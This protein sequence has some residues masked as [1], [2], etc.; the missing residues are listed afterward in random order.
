MSFNVFALLLSLC[1]FP[2]HILAI[3]QRRISPTQHTQWHQGDRAHDDNTLNITIALALPDSNHAVAALLEIAD[4]SSSQY[5]QHWSA[6]QVVQTFRPAPD[7]TIKV[8]DWLESSGIHEYLNISSGAGGYLRV[9]VTVHEASHLLNT[10]FHLYKNERTGDEHI[11]SEDYYIPKEIS[12]HVVYILATSMYRSEEKRNIKRAMA[13][14][15]R[16]SD[17]TFDCK[18]Y[19]TPSCLRELYGIPKSVVSNTHNSFG[20][21]EQAWQTWLPSDLDSFFTLFAPELKGKRPIMELV[22][23]GYTQTELQNRAFNTE[24]NLDFQYAM[25]LTSPQD[26]INLQVGDMYRLGEAP[27]SLP[28]GHLNLMLAAFDRYYCDSLDPEIDPQF[29]N[30]QPHGYNKSTDCGTIKPPG[31]ISISYTFPEAAFPPEYLERQCMEYLKL[32]LMGVTVLVSVS[33]SGTG[34]SSVPT[35]NDAA[36]GL[37]R[38]RE[39]G[40]ITATVGLFNPSFPAS[41]PWVTAVGGTQRYTQSNTNVSVQPIHQDVICAKNYSI[42]Q[43]E[44]AFYHL[45]SSGAV[46][47]SGGGFSNVFPAPSYQR[48]DTRSY[49]QTEATH[50]SHFRD[51]FNMSGRGYPDVS[52][53]AEGY[54]TMVDGQLRV[55]RGSSASTPVFASVVT[56]LN[57]EREKVGK[58]RLGFLNPALYSQPH[59]LNDIVT[60][61]N[62][63]CGVNPAFQATCG[64]DPVTGL[65]TPNYEKM[66]DFFVNLP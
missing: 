44:T 1:F 39:S 37:C 51:R 59:I 65:G 50:L 9:L 36:L 21:Y 47:S 48:K 27:Q 6:T 64:W 45:S 52:A 34:S 8:L 46:S 56:L 16:P 55:I 57:N 11:A 58:R 53:Q 40:A 33:D 23:G 7:T 25:A 14:I 10:T 49:K 66:L 17:A 30:D 22:D 18:K 62:E 2:H 31:V 43:D 41:C 4:P 38:D 54:L 42:S 19:T 29:P 63:G 26:V 32:G 20:I 3:S 12:Q 28:L 35:E 13:P 24:A 61:A 60:G 15:I 5:G